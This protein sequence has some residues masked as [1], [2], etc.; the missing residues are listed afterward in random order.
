LKKPRNVYDRMVVTAMQNAR[1]HRASATDH[2]HAI[3]RLHHSAVGGRGL[4]YLL[5]DARARR[6]FEYQQ[7]RDAVKDARGLIRDSRRYERQWPA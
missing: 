2:E 5:S 6:D 4:A 1:E 7:M 3:H